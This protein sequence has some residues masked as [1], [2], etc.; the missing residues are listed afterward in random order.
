MALL[1]ISLLAPLLCDFTLNQIGLLATPSLLPAPAWLFGS[2][3]KHSSCYCTASL[4]THVPT[5]AQPQSKHYQ[6]QV[7][8]EIK[9]EGWSLWSSFSF[10][11]HYFFSNHVLLAPQGTSVWLSVWSTESSEMLAFLPSPFA[12]ALE[13]RMKS[14]KW[15][16]LTCQG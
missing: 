1:N 16:E 2:Y 12:W 4:G 13:L 8:S 6:P 10:L 5:G 3:L 15:D 7:F 9:C 11:L 14:G